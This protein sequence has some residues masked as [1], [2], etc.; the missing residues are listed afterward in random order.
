MHI[1]DENGLLSD[2][3]YAEGFPLAQGAINAHPQGRPVSQPGAG[4]NPA[5]IRI[6]QDDIRAVQL[7]KAAIRA[8]AETLPLACGFTSRDIDNVLVAGAFGAALNFSRLEPIGLLPPGLLARCRSVGNTSL[9]GA[10]KAATM[11]LTGHKEHLMDDLSH[12]TSVSS[13]VPLAGRQDFEACYL[14]MMG[15]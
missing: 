10:V 4:D 3:W 1:I 8:G 2:P 13:E 15:F 6:Y 12:I 14:S 7:A 5:G 9:K 11:L